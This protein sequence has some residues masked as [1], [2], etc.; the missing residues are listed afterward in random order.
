MR[1]RQMKIFS[2]AFMG[3]LSL[4]L[5]TMSCSKE[6]KTTES[7]SDAV[8]NAAAKMK[9]GLVLDRGGR[10]DKS[11]NAAAFK[12]A[13]EATKDLGIEL[14]DVES[15]NDSS[16]EPALRSL[17]ER[18]Y[19]L[20]IAIGF[21]QKEALEKIAPQFPNTKF[22][23]IDAPIEMPNV[24]SKM[25]AEHEGSYMV[26]YLAGLATKTNTVGFVGGMDIPLIRR[27]YMAYSAGAKAANS[28]IN[29]LETYV[30]NTSEAW[31][32]PSRAKEL[33]LA[34]YN[35]KSDIIFTAAGASSM[36]VFDAAE[37]KKL[38]AIGVDSNQNWVKPGLILSSM[39]K[40]VDLA[41][42]NV[43]KDTFD[44]KFVAGKSV[45]NLKDAG[46]G[47]AVDEYNEKL[48]APYKMKLEEVKSDIISGKIAVPD[49]Y[50]SGNIKL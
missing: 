10:D 9:V 36:G 37:E 13:S 2:T 21:A 8:T 47:Y 38:F 33:A 25:F 6:T 20:V 30:G 46:V 28:K 39:L 40:R 11:F 41:V 43:I 5:V 14:K 19:Q 18:G 50:Q 4:T 24:Q 48:I 22:A 17:A 34:Q 3:M 1:Q 42:A 44:N 7:A 15:P 27:F 12:G 26:G 35:N 45:M 49:Y 16:F 31:A 23:I 29:V 32:N